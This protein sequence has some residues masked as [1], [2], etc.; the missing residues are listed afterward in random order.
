MVGHIGFISSVVIGRCLDII[1]DDVIF[2][3]VNGLQLLF[4]L[5]LARIGLFEDMHDA[6]LLNLLGIRGRDLG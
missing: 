5:L 4:Q 2:L 3:L 1:E 6:I